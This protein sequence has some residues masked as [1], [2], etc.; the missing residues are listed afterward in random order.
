MEGKRAAAATLCYCVLAILSVVSVSSQQQQH[1]VAGFAGFCGCFGDC[2]HDCRGEGRPRWLCTVKC[3][4]A[5]AIDSSHE[6]PSA[7]AAAALAAG[8][9]SAI[10]LAAVCGAADTASDRSTAAE[11]AACVDDCTG[12]WN[13][14]KNKRA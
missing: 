13:T 8:D 3:V 4:E 10:C 14:Y 1:Q 7:A 11:D 9:C 2:S 6:L 12:S 5:C